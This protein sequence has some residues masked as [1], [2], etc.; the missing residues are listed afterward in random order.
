MEGDQTDR[1]S[2]SPSYLT[3]QQDN[4]S[5]QKTPHNFL[6]KLQGTLVKP[7]YREDTDMQFMTAEEFK[8]ASFTE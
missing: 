3:A 1:D 5:Y 7:A 8:Y 6:P 2:K 4:Q